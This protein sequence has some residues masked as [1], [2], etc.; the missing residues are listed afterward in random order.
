MMHLVHLFIDTKS[1][2]LGLPID[3]M[4]PE[5]NRVTRSQRQGTIWRK[6]PGRN[7]GLGRRTQATLGEVAGNQPRK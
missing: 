5:H 6:R 2:E 7:L 3:L 4:R 1:K